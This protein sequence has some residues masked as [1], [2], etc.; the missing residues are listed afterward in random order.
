MEVVASGRFELWDLDCRGWWAG[1]FKDAE[2]ALD[3]KLPFLL[4]K[5]SAM[6]PS[7]VDGLLDGKR[8]FSRSV[9]ADFCGGADA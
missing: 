9:L 7:L 2:P 1:A 6:L 8:L 4:L 5:E 3:G